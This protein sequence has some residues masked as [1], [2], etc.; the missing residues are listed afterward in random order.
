MSRVD[1]PLPMLQVEVCFL[2]FRLVSGRCH[3]ISTIHQWAPD[4]HRTGYVVF[5]HPALQTGSR[6]S[7]SDSRFSFVAAF[8]I[9]HHVG[10][11]NT[12]KPFFRLWTIR[13]SALFVKPR[14]T[15]YCYGA[16][17][18]LERCVEV[19]KG[20][21]AMTANQELL[22]PAEQNREEIWGWL[23][24]KPISFSQEAGGI[25]IGIFRVYI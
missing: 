15:P 20:K 21:D 6:I 22:I 5:P 18:P 13:D 25:G 9:L 10:F 19:R 3:Y 2:R 23:C 7:R 16:N 17:S 1:Q 12:E 14:A 24:H 4:P 8:G 11:F